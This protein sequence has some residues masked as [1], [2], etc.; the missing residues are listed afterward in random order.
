[1]LEKSE[2][3]KAF[4]W[5]NLKPHL[6]NQVM[7]QKHIAQM[8]SISSMIYTANLVFPIP[9]L[10]LLLSFIAKGLRDDFLI[11]YRKQRYRFSWRLIIKRFKTSITL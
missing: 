8:F 1:M 11:R 4:R 3:C 7:W 9:H 2:P 6:L 5:R 10:I